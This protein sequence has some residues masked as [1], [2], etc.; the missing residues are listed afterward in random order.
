M[1]NP[2]VSLAFLTL[3]SL[4]GLGAAA[5]E[6]KAS[7]TEAASGGHAAADAEPGTWADWCGE[8]A[9]PE[10]QCTQCHKDLIPAFKATGDW[11]A[12]HGLPKSQ[13]KKC[14]PSL[15]IERP[16]KPAEQP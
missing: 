15:V 2:I 1:K 4:L 16:P 7:H 6:E 8:H 14:D 5:C 9:V 10:S 13:C 3:V 11:C 12:D